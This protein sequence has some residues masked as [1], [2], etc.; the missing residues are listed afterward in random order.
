MI[1]LDTHIWVKWVLDEKQLPK[2]E[3]KLVARHE[4]DGLGVSVISCWEV[5]KLV[6]L[7]RLKFGHVSYTPKSS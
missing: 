7:K 5:A 3:R 4:E 6:E 1:L 2:P